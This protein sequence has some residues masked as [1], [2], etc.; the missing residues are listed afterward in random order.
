MEQVLGDKKGCSGCGACIR[1]CPVNAITPR[2]KEHPPCSDFLDETKIRFAPRYGCG[3]CQVQ[4]PC[5]SGIPAR[6]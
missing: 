4:V 6:P 5:M 2:G 1:R 3:K